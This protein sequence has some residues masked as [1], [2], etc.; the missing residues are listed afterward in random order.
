[1]TSIPLLS[2][3][4][5]STL[6]LLVVGTLMVVTGC[7]SRPQIQATPPARGGILDYGQD[8]Q[9]VAGGIDPYVTTAFAGQNVLTQIYESLLTK[10]DQGT[11]QPGIAERWEVSADTLQ[12]T[13][14]LRPGVT[15]SDGTPLTGDDVAFSF[16]TMKETGA[17]QKALLGA[18]GR[19]EVPDPQTVVFH[20]TRPSGTFINV[21]AGAQLG[22]IVNKKWYTSTPAAQRQKSALGTGPFRLTEWQD[23]VVLRLRRNDHYWNQPYPYLDGINFWIFPDDQARL[24]ALR[25][26]TVTALW[27]GDQQL[28][29]QVRPE[30]F[31]VG[32][33]AETRVLM[34]YVNS[35]AGAM[36]DL[37]VRRAASKALNRPQAAKLA[38][39]GYGKLSLIVP[40]GDPTGEPPPADTPNYSYD[41]Q[42]ARQLLAQAGKEG[43]TIPLTYPS[44][45]SF[46]RDQA[47]Y[48]VMKEQYRQV[49]INLQLNPIPWADVLSRYAT[50]NYEGMLAAPGVAQPDP[51]A[52]FAAWMA[53]G[54]KSPVSE[55]DSAASRQLLDE[56]IGTT[57]PAARAQ[58]LARLEREVADKVIVLAPYVVAQRQEVWSPRLQGYRPDPYS[59][60]QNLKKAWLAP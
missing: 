49:G 30:G 23:S 52:Y 37:T 16:Q 58:V 42:G 27:L 55:T 44:D 21:A 38:S 43:I 1:M 46:A 24:A 9:P 8:V 5:R 57:D 60:R 40:P 17:L 10:D 2:R 28:V 11:I 50:G 45:A 20:L 59:I 32:Q 26:G 13:F 47:L 12:Y 56:L 51:S 4:L 7:V 25:Q 14:R 34:L 39:Y 19:I 18:L 3:L 48:E 35:K 36:S 33:N 29:E 53:K 31:E 6:G 54:A 22:F 41:P 15:F